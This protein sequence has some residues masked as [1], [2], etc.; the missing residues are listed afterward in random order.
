MTLLDLTWQTLFCTKQTH[1]CENPA[2]GICGTHLDYHCSP[3]LTLWSL[4]F[5]KLFLKLMTCQFEMRK[6]LVFWR[7]LS[8]MVPLWNCWSHWRS[9]SIYCSFALISQVRMSCLHFSPSTKQ[10]LNISFPRALKRPKRTGICCQNIILPFSTQQKANFQLTTNRSSSISIRTSVVPV[11]FL[12]HWHAVQ[13]DF[14][15]DWQWEWSVSHNSLQS[16]VSLLHNPW[17]CVQW[18][19][20]PIQTERW[21]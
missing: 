10:I 14:I 12:P 21:G 11:L 8:P 4:A 15:E 2:H 7:N 3:T 13:F 17:V 18:W 9:D 19:W 20:H 6:C 16:A 5:W 1:G